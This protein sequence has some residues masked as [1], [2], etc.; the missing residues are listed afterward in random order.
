VGNSAT[1]FP[2]GSEAICIVECSGLWVVNQSFGISWRPAQIKVYKN[3][4]KLQEAAF[5]E[6]DS[7]EDDT[8]ESEEKVEDSPQETAKPP[9]DLFDD[10]EEAEQLDDL[11]G[12]VAEPVAA[13]KPVRRR[14]NEK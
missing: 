5:L 11:D 9:C 14:K 10:D 13:S 12:E 7:D 2:K 1:V 8:Q 4:M 3:E 6:E